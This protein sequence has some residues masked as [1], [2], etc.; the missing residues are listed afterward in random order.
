VVREIERT[1]GNRGRR[2]GGDAAA[3][4]AGY[5]RPQ[6]T[7]LCRTAR[8]ARQLVGQR[9]SAMANPVIAGA[10]G[11]AHPLRPERPQGTRAD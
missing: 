5:G 10:P 9:R 3:T 11:R 8:G 6:L 4:R 1:A 7:G 2:P